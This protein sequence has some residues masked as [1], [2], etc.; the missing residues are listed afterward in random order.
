M[1]SLQATPKT[2]VPQELTR[3][4]HRIPWTSLAVRSEQAG[5]AVSANRDVQLRH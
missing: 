4:K 1:S 5:T 3:F 2:L